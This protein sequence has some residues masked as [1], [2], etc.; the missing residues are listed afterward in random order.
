LRPPPH[1][2]R[3][4]PVLT[5]SQTDYEGIPMRKYQ[6]RTYRLRTAAAATDYLPHWQLHVRSLKLYG[7]E[8]HAFF[9]VPSA[10]QTVIALVSFDEHVDPEVV[11]GEYMK[12]DAFKEDMN[13]FDVAQIE[14]V[15]TLLLKPGEGSPLT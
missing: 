2:K 6:L 5:S 11:A 7:V 14:G 13:G 12:S 10:P 8:T 4:T 15:E 1:D 9:S 3:E